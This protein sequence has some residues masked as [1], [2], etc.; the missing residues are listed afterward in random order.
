MKMIP[1]LKRV[2]GRL[3]EAPE[4]DESKLDVK[5]YEHGS[6]PF[7]SKEIGYDHFSKTFPEFK[8]RLEQRA[9][10]FLGKDWKKFIEQK[11]GASHVAIDRAIKNL[12]DGN[13]TDYEATLDVFHWFDA[14]QNE[15][16][17]S[18]QEIRDVIEQEK[19]VSLGDYRF[20]SDDDLYADFGNRP[21]R[22]V[23][24]ESNGELIYK[25]SL[26]KS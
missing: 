10:R 12:W 24:V 18:P 14:A 16:G 21:G 20:R 25:V 8:V 26:E 7:D 1:S 22:P 17:Y 23:G 11:T 19:Q 3:F 13:F 9:V 2:F 4:G 15:L 6:L 5:H